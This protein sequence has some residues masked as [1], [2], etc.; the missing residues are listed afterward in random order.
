MTFQLARRTRIVMLTV[1]VPRDRSAS[2]NVRPPRYLRTDIEDD[3]T[4]ERI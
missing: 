3:W 4:S 1:P 2:Q